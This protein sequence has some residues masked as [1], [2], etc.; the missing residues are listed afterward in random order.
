MGKPNNTIESLLNRVSK[1]SNGCWIWTGSLTAGSY[2]QTRYNG[3]LWRAHRLFYTL[4]KSEI[5]NKLMV[6]H[7]CDNP[8]CVNPDHLFLGTNQDNLSDMVRKGRARNQ[9]TGKLV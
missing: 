5:P 6:C 1:A 8:Q 3:K 4:F 9:W 7:H 2:G